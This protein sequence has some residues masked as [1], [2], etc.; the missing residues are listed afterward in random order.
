MNIFIIGMM[1]AGKSTVGA[2]IAE[3]IGYKFVDTDNLIEQA[4]GNINDIFKIHSETVFRDYESR[5]LDKFIQESNCEPLSKYVIA[6]GG[7]IILSKKNR[8]LMKRNGAIVFLEA[9]MDTL[10]KRL[11]DSASRPLINMNNSHST[12]Q[13][14]ELIYQARESIY[15]SICDYHIVVDKMSKQNVADEVISIILREC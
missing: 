8:E 15:K 9:S 3:K 13:S 4:Y 10:A 14:L 12:L 1:G 5:I 2:I 11:N 7:G 6:T